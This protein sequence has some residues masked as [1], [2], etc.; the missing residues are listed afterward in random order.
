M[1]TTEQIYEE[2]KELYA[3]RTGLYIDDGGDMALRLYAAAAQLYSLWV[4][5]D[6]VDRQAYPQ[7]ATGE[8]LD[9]HAQL[10]GLERGAATHA[11][12]TIRFETSE[13]RTADLTVPAGTRCMTAAGAEFITTAAAVIPAGSLHC[14]AAARAAEAGSAG[15][16]PI[17]S[18]LYMALAPVG[19]TSCWNPEKFTGGADAE[20]DDAL[21]ARV[22]ASYRKLPNGANVAYYEA[23]AMDVDG[24]AAVSVI[25]KNRG[26][27]TVD[28]VIAAE[29]G[30]PTQDMIRAVQDRLDAQ[31]EI[32]V[33]IQV[34]APEAVTVNVSAAIDCESGYAYADVSEAVEAAVEAYFTGARLGKDLLRAEL[35]NLIFHVK[36][37]KNY[38]IALPAADVAIDADQLPVLGTLAVSQMGV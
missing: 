5:A 31:R 2:M 29:G 23:Q 22:I 15:N 13:V 1:K 35:G 18:I 25:P 32:C 21:R 30:T 36:G 3:R 20:D 28:V 38:S 11:Q 9:Y 33:D 17:E 10:R 34:L 14:Q 37:V 19:V 6:Y 27:G 8:H 24:V 26:L 12:G 16:V 7:T 4:Q